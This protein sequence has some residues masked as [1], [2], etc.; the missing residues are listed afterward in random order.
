[1]ATCGGRGRRCERRIAGRAP[2]SGHAA[3]SQSTASSPGW[4][5]ST[6][7]DH[8]LIVFAR[9]DDYFFGVLHSRVHEVWAL[10]Q[11]TQLR[12]RERGFRYTPTTCFETFPFPWPTPEQ[13][14][15]AIRGAARREAAA[16]RRLRSALAQPAGVDARGGPGVPRLG[17]RPV[18]AL[19]RTTP[20]PAASA[21]CATRASSP[22][23][24][25]C[26]AKLK[27][28]TLTNLYNQRP[29]WLALAHRK[30]DDAV[31]AAYGWD[32]AHVRRRPPRVPP[33][34]QPRPRRRG[35]ATMNPR[36]ALE[37]VL[38]R[39]ARRAFR[40]CAFPRPCFRLRAMPHQWQPPHPRRRRR[41]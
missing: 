11:G 35:N 8:Q 33:R 5:E 4:P 18:G 7:P 28:R 37:R 20:T 22:K 36:K 12:E 2:V 32:P 14:P 41:C 29:T 26:A 38:R 19:R 27:A 25:D 3:T 30:L 16:T 1:M 31:F 13:E 15:R 17:R 9:S 6:L 24:A 39:L 34:P 40:R 23:D 21:P 10:A